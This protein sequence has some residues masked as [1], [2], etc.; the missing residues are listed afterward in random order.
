MN[1]LVSGSHGLIG[2][3]VVGALARAGHRV[4]RL[5]RGQGGAGVDCVAWD[6]AEARIDAAGLEGLDG[7]I[8]LAGE[9]IAQGRW[10]EQKKQRIYASR[11]EGTGLLCRTLAGLRSRP[12]VV[13]CA[14]A[15][16]FYG[17]RGDEE[18]DETSPA[19][20]GFLA[21]VCRDWEAATAA[22]AEA[23]IRVVR[24]RIGTVLSRDGGAL[25]AMLPIFRLGLGGRLGSGRQYMSW[26]AVDDLARIVIQTIGDDQMSG[27][28]NAVAP[29]PVTNA[30]FTRLL[31]RALRR[32]AWIPVPAFVLRTV[33]GEMA[34]AAL[35]SSARV[36]P[37]RLLASGFVFQDQDLEQFFRHTLAGGG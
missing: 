2:S 10:T 27:P 30:Q 36:H 7:V 12:R 33:V 15:V 9:S 23:G 16:G 18:L 21:E 37:K 6:P 5:V 26:I 24:L 25:A 13:V 22:A 28:V 1:V 32:P 4:V 11:I 31:G 35:L 20:K 29:N 17:D 3:A 14:S 8:H 34:D 19:G